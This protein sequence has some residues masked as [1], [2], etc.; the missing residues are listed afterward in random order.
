M[1]INSPSLF[2]AWSSNMGLCG[3]KIYEEVESNSEQNYPVY[4]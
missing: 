2:I 1:Q 4:L 3:H